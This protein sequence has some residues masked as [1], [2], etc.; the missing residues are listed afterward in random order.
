MRKLS[1]GIVSDCHFRDRVPR[2]MIKVFQAAFPKFCQANVDMIPRLREKHDY[3][4]QIFVR[5]SES[6]REIAHNRGGRKWQFSFFWNNFR[7]IVFFVSG[8]IGPFFPASYC[9]NKLQWSKY[10]ILQLP[11]FSFYFLSH[12]VVR[13]R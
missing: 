8:Q 11:S 5:H 13:T 6:F 4:S 2:Y 3:H 9:E 7:R 1:A 12:Y 10:L